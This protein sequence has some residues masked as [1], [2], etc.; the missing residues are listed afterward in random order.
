[1]IQRRRWKH[2]LRTFDW[3]NDSEDTARWLRAVG[4][5]AE[6]NAIIAG[7]VHYL[8]TGI[9]PHACKC[10]RLGM[11][12]F[13]DPRELCQTCHEEELATRFWDKNRNV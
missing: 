5:K 2:D 9:K 10:G 12:S 3:F 11:D 4:R 7:Y 13:G 6:S 8:K 1:M